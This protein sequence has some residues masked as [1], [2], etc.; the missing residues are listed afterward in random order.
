MILYV[1]ICNYCVR[2]YVVDIVCQC[3]TPH[4]HLIFRLYTVCVIVWIILGYYMDTIRKFRLYMYNMKRKQNSTDLDY[5]SNCDDL[6][7]LFL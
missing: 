6:L 3:I 2:G 5:H 7:C 4:F 1:K